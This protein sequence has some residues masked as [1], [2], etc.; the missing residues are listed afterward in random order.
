ML[1]AD[2][3]KQS[4][5][6]IAELLVVIAIIGV[7]VAVSIPIFTNQKEKAAN[8]TDVYNAKAIARQIEYY[9]MSNPDKLENLLAI[10][11]ESPGSMQVIV[12]QDGM[13]FSTHTNGGKGCSTAK[14]KAVEADMKEL[15]GEYDSK[16]TKTG[17][18]DCLSAYKCK[19][20]KKWKQ[21][22]VIFSMYNISTKKTTTYPN[23]YYGAW[24][25]AEYD[26][27][28]KWDTLT[29]DNGALKNFIT[30]TGT[31]IIVE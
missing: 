26:G 27:G 17:S 23:L 4:G 16:L 1:F 2:K 18:A 15:F 3:R 25:S 13:V 24:D 7:L 19:S 28:Y 6:T 31:G 29:K 14:D 9:Y 11:E 12:L 10:E 20:T 21:Y 22:A 5:F 8:A 30:V